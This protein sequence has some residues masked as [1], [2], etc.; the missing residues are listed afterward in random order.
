MGNPDTMNMNAKFFVLKQQ[1][2]SKAK[3]DDHFALAAQVAADQYRNGQRVFICVN[4][5]ETACAFVFISVFIC[6]NGDTTIYDRQ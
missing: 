1:D 5:N 2:E 6:N 4:D 3:A